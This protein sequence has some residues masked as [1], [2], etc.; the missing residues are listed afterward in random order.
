MG[1]IGNVLAISEM[2]DNALLLK[3]QS[4]THT[5]DFLLNRSPG[6]Q[7]EDP[8]AEFFGLFDE[9]FEKTRPY[10][11]HLVARPTDQEVVQ[12]FL[13]AAVQEI[14]RGVLTNPG[15]FEE[16]SPSILDLPSLNGFAARWSVLDFLFSLIEA[17]K[18]NGSEKPSE[19]G[20]IVRFGEGVHLCAAVLLC[21]TGQRS[22]F[23]PLSIGAKIS[24]HFET[25]FSSGGKGARVKKFITVNKLVSAGF[26]CAVSVLQRMVD[27]I[28]RRK[29]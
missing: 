22:L 8:G 9:T 18:V 14:A 21:I 1:E 23:K 5:A 15:L 24:A 12:P 26:H 29:K 7:P 17:E 19:I 25:D 10:F 11:S 28:I 2:M 13:Y 4:E 6:N 16:T 27:L 20:S 3:R